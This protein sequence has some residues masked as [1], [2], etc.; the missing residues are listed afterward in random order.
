MEPLSAG[1]LRGKKRVVCRRQ[2]LGGVSNG[3]EKKELGGRGTDDGGTVENWSALTW[4]FNTGTRKPLERKKKINNWGEPTLCRS[5]ILRKKKKRLSGQKKKKRRAEEG[6]RRGGCSL[7]RR[8]TIWA[9]CSKTRKWNKC[10][11]RA[12]RPRPCSTSR[13]YDEKKVAQQKQGAQERGQQR[14]RHRHDEQKR[15]FRKANKH[16]GAEHAGCHTWKGFPHQREKRQIVRR[17][18]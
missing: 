17:G 16:G 4:S 6:P 2:G 7:V 9:H 12:G 5:T 13:N 18:A 14:K 11:R 10:A 15:I 8:G 1:K 3:E